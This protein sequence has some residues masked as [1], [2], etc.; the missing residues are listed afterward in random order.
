MRGRGLEVAG[1]GVW[2]SVVTFSEIGNTES[3]A[4]LEE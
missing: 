3:R 4:G 2:A 1:E